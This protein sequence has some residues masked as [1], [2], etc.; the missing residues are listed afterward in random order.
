MEKLDLKKQEKAFYSPKKGKLVHVDVPEYNFLM[1]DAKDAR[2]EGPVFSQAI[3]AIFS[4]A[5]KIKFFSKIE[6][7]K[8]FAVMPLEG[9]WWG[10]NKEV[11]VSG[12]KEKWEYTLMIHQP[13]W[14]TKD[15]LD[16]IYPKAQEKDDNPFLAKARIATFREGPSVQTLHIGPFSEEGPTIDA[17]KD[18]IHASGHTFDG[19]SQKHHEIYLSDFRRTAPEKL[20]TILRQ[21]YVKLTDE[22]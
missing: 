2:P 4:L 7:G 5:Y 17:I 21:S 3:G 1:I 14:I 6:L 11:F 10:E 19:Q 16:L 18:E 15:I 8:D 13:E 20:K 22:Q 12:D 9:L